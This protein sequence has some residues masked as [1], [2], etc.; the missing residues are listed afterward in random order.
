MRT[1]WR[2]EVC[3]DCNGDREREWKV[4]TVTK[5]FTVPKGWR[6][7]SRLGVHKTIAAPTRWTTLCE[8]DA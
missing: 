2:S 8:C 5:T 7:E 6:V 3:D 4:K 1:E